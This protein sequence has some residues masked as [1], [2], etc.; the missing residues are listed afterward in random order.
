MDELITILGKELP[1]GQALDVVMKD[2]QEIL[3]NAHCSTRE[4]IFLPDTVESSF[5]KSYEVANDVQDM[6]HELKIL[7]GELDKIMKKVPFKPEDNEEKEWVKEYNIERKNKR[8]D[9]VV[10]I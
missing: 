6:V 3:N 10:K 2:I 9:I 5:K 1:V 7:L 8:K 4:I